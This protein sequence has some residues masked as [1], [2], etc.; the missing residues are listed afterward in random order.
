[1]YG[2]TLPAQGPWK[3]GV[4]IQVGDLVWQDPNDGY[5]IK[6]AAAFP[7]QGSYAATLALFVQYFLGVS[8]QRYDSTRPLIT[9]SQQVGVQDGNIRFSTA[10]VFRYPVLPGTNLNVGDFI[11]PALDPVTGTLL[12]SQFVIGCTAAG[13]STANSIGRCERQLT[14]GSTVYMR[15]FT[16]RLEQGHT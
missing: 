11:V 16:E 5:T 13:I 8:A 7:P 9:F 6:P 1:M 2:G 15:L 10:G 3:A 14:N 4:S 12:Q